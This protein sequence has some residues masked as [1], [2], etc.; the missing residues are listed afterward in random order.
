MTLRG[1][2]ACVQLTESERTKIDSLGTDERAKLRHAL[3]L[4]TLKESYVKATGEG[5]HHDLSQIGF[6]INLPRAARHDQVD[7]V[8]SVCLSDR[9]SVDKWTFDLV[10]VNEGENRYLVAL[11]QSDSEDGRGR[12][13]WWA[14]KPDWIK[15]VTLHDVLESTRNGSCT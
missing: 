7:V 11:A 10:E 13:R 2:R 1:V 6:D 15:F 5:L 3:A 8:G 14:H 9:E 12:V 4:W